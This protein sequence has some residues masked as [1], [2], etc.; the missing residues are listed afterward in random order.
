MEGEEKDKK[1]KKELEL[2]LAEAKAEISKLKQAHKEVEEEWKKEAAMHRATAAD[3]ARAAADAA[4]TGPSG[5]G[6]GPGYQTVSMA[7]GGSQLMSGRFGTRNPPKHPNEPGKFMSWSRRMRTFLAVEGLEQTLD[8]QPPT[9]YVHIIGCPDRN[10]LN[11]IH[12]APL[13]TAHLRAWGYLVEST[14]GSDI[15]ETLFAC[16][17]VP[18]A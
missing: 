3:A 16:S 5:G 4:R 1:Q 2:G 9:G 12:G 6:S 8:H 11:R 10:Y 14:S 7:D 18:E 15:E 17:C 13:V